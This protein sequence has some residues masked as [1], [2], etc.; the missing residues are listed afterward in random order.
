MDPVYVAKTEEDKRMQRALLHFNKRE[1]RA[2]VIKALRKADRDDLIPVL[3]GTSGKS[4][5][6]GKTEH[7]RRDR[8]R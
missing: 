2:L 6:T 8:R 5:K 7:R 1:N 3:A 4:G